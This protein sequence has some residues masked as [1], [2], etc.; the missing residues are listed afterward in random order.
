MSYSSDLLAQA[1]HLAEKEPKRPKQASLKRAVSAA[2]YTLFHF[3]VSEAA[4]YMV[5]GAG[6]SDIRPIFQRAFAH[7]HMKSVAKAFAGGTLSD[8]WKIL[9]GHPVLPELHDVAVAFVELQEARHEA[10]SSS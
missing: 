7:G 5:K 9:V 8:R 6:A 2:Y 4:L 10:E 3:L 1:K